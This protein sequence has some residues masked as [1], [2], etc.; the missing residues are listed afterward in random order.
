MPQTYY[1]STRMSILLM[2]ALW[3]MPSRVQA[4]NFGGDTLLLHQADGQTTH[5]QFGYSVANA[6]DIDGDGIDDL[7][8][9]APKAPSG[10]LIRSGSAF[11]ISGAD[12]SVLYRWN[13]TLDRA[14][15]GQSVAAA[16]DVNLDGYGDLIV[17]APAEGRYGKAY[18]YSGKDGSMLHS[19]SG[20]PKNPS[21]GTSVSSAGDVNQDGHADLIIGAPRADPGGVYDAG[22]A[23]V[24]SGKDGYLLYKWGGFRPED[25]F[26]TSVAGT[27]DV[28][29]DGFDDL[30]VGAPYPRG[31]FYDSQPG[32]AYLYS[33][34][35][36]SILHQ[37]EGESANSDFGHSVARVSDLDGD[38]I[39]DLII[40]APFAAP[41][42]LRAAGSAFVYSGATGSLIHRFH[43]QA[44]KDQFGWAVASAGDIDGNGIDDLIIGANNATPNGKLWAGSAFA[45]SG[46]DGA[47]I[48]QWD[49][50]ATRDRLGS[51]V[52][53]AGDSNLNGRS[54]VILGAPFASPLGAHEAG[55]AYVYS[56]LPFLHANTS[57]ISASS[58]GTLDME[59]S[60]PDSSRFNRY[61][62]LISATGTGPTNYGIPI[63]LSQDSL[64]TQS[65]FGDYPFP[66]HLALQG[67]LDAN[68]YAW[69]QIT[70]PA[71]MPTSLIGNTYYLAAITNPVGELPNYSSV[72]TPLTVLP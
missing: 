60:F 1:P 52:S 5:D 35:D 58:G 18:V 50:E 28:N 14:S 46:V 44:A 59:L 15:F 34:A 31:S 7:I 64:L 41:N 69:A 16:G 57:T 45:Y 3:S 11:V 23:L 47:L 43:G 17:G 19:W 62:I 67:T 32:S 13:G 61:K 49:G 63:P 72:A 20:T 8:L 39:S 71:G 12:Q 2:A 66:T 55:T 33:G 29:Q 54:E 51:S 42:G 24:Y 22:S 4:Q 10:N 6:G 37:W 70:A 9:G 53:S 65:F 36:G 30:L 40:G 27:G 21:L 25:Y 48:R 56:F 26:G 38:G 68:G